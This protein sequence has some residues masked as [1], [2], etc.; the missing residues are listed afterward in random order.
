MFQY[1]GE[2][3]R[4]PQKLT[5]LLYRLLY[6]QLGQHPPDYK[7]VTLTELGKQPM[8]TKTDHV[9]VQYPAGVVWVSDWDE[10]VPIRAATSAAL[11][12]LTQSQSPGTETRGHASDLTVR[13]AVN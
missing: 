8:T 11:P 6:G 3:Y 13:V 2:H 9:N 1:I 4:T 12:A 5:A 10:G 7:Y